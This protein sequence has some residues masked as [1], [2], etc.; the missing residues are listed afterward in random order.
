MR[1]FAYADDNGN[2]KLK[3]YVSDDGAPP[4]EYRVSIVAASTNPA[5]LSK[6]APIQDEAPT[7]AAVMIPQTISK[8]YGNVETA[9]IT[10]LIK[11]EG[12]QL[13]PFQLQ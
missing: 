2:F 4:G 6:D 12:N 13:E 8:K 11:P 5:G 10:V 1:P 7:M 3:T 9:G